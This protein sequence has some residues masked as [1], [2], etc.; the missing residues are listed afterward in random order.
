MGALACLKQLAAPVDV[1]LGARMNDNAILRDL[2][3]WF[4]GPVLVL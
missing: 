3:A 1:V 2:G 4:I